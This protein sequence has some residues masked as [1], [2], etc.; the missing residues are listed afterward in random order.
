MTHAPVSETI[1]FHCRVAQYIGHKLSALPAII[2]ADLVGLDAEQV[3][4]RLKKAC[5]EVGQDM[6]ARAEDYISTLEAA[7]DESQ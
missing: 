3:Q 6:A 7:K 5:N 1:D 4:A 2:A